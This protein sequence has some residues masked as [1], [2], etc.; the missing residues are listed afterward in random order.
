M[1]THSVLV[2]GANL[3]RIEQNLE[4]TASTGAT[5]LEG[6]LVPV[7]RLGAGAATVRSYWVHGVLLPYRARSGTV[8]TADGWREVQTPGRS[9]S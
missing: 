7:V 4:D 3:G 2:D 9:P 6:L 8:L 1:T 5:H